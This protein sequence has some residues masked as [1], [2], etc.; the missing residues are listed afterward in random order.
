MRQHGNKSKLLHITKNTCVPMPFFL[1][2]CRYYTTSWR[3]RDEARQICTF[4]VRPPT[5]QTT[6][7]SR[8]ATGLVFKYRKVR[9]QCTVLLSIDRREESYLKYGFG[10]L[11]DVLQTAT[12]MKRRRIDD[13]DAD[14]D[15]SASKC[16]AVATFTCVLVYGLAYVSISM[17]KF[18][19]YSYY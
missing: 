18:F 14:A 17:P 13:A 16:V 8:I 1:I 15:A 11:N 5:D 9:I 19:A 6:T 3:G 12:A 7:F 10:N 2:T 4:P